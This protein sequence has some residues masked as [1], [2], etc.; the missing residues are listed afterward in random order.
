MN[1]MMALFFGCTV[2]GLVF[3][4]LGAREGWIIGGFALLLTALYFVFPNRFM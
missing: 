3:R 2:A 4:R 1:L